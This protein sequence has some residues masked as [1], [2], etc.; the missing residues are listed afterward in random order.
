MNSE[1][2]NNP[3]ILSNEL[4]QA[5]KVWKSYEERLHEPELQQRIFDAMDQHFVFVSEEWDWKEILN[6]IWLHENDLPWP[7]I[8]KSKRSKVS[9]LVHKEKKQYNSWR[10][11][12][13]WAPIDARHQF[14]QLWEIF[15]KNKD[16][17]DEGEIWTFITFTKM[18]DGKTIVWAEQIEIPQTNP[19]F[20]SWYAC[21]KKLKSAEF[22]KILSW[23]T[24]LNKPKIEKKEEIIEK[25]EAT[26][27]PRKLWELFKK[28]FKK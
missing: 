27:K 6:W 2:S 3:N 8:Y 20:P 22:E 25:E 13:I 21:H 5:P 28:L 4:D 18:D 16:K 23:S 24:Y 1:I 26:Q 19:F 15:Y 17:L 12:M 10:S 7:L 11:P 14:S 9:F